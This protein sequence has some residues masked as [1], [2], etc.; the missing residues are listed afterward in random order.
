MRT[1]VTATF[2]LAAIAVPV[3]AAASRGDSSGAQTPPPSALAPA[4]PATDGASALRSVPASVPVRESVPELLLAPAALAPA[5]A[6]A[7]LVP[8]PVLAPLLSPAPVRESVPAPLLAPAPSAPAPA[9]GGAP[10]PA[11]EPPSSQPLPDAQSSPT[12]TIEGLES[13]RKPEP[14]RVPEKVTLENVPALVPQDHLAGATATLPSG[15][16]P[17]LVQIAR[18]RDKQKDGGGDVQVPLDGDRPARPAPSAPARPAPSASARPAPSA[19]AHPAQ[20][21]RTGLDV[22]PLA[23]M[24]LAM[25]IAGLAVL[26]VSRLG[27]AAARQPTG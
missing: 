22:M 17:R 21:P 4:S 18:V 14:E 9:A 15:D 7:P 8:V 2:L 19:S 25:L 27:R 12:P 23:A 1:F 5:L 3:Q 16:E 20:L 26:R 11:P 10:V 6:P 24:G 13:P